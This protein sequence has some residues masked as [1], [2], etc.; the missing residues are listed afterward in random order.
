MSHHNADRAPRDLLQH[1]QE[2]P[3]QRSNGSPLITGPVPDPNLAPPSR[4]C[5]PAQINGFNFA[6]DPVFT[7]NVTTYVVYLD[8]FAENSTLDFTVAWADPDINAV[9]LTRVRAG[10]G[11]AARR[12]GVRE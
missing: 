1:H 12:A 7:T 11:V 6:S 3:S 10:G 9:W 2:A 5:R 4:P 8:E